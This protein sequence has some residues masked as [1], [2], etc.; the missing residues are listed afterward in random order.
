V[1]NSKDQRS[2]KREQ[3]SAERKAG[4]RRTTC[5]IVMLVVAAGVVGYVLITGN[6]AH[7]K[8]VAGAEIRIPASEIGS[9]AKFFEY[10]TPGNKVVRF[11]VIKSSDGVYRAAADA[12]DVCYRSKLGYY[13]DGDDM[14]CRN[15]GQRFASRNV[16][17]LTGGCNPSGVPVHLEGDKLVIAAAD[18]NAHEYMF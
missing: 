3:F 2:H 4:S 8:R 1:G 18:L 6:G 11:F 17:L 13:Q 5:L 9:T 7:A 14:V 16:N 12:C 10:P 15:C